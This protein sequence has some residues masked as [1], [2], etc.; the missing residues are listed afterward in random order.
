MVVKRKKKEYVIYES[1]PA[2]PM[3]GRRF[4][5]FATRGRP[6]RQVVDGLPPT[7][8]HSRYT[9]IETTSQKEALKIA[10]R[11]YGKMPGPRMGRI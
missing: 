1:W 9:T 2:Y 6:W 10:K 3:R 4:G 5:A 8:V 7:V 11:E